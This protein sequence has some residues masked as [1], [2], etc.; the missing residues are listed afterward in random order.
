MSSLKLFIIYK[1]KGYAMIIKSNIKA[2]GIINHNEKLASDNKV[3]SFTVKTGIKAG[4]NFTKIEYNNHNE[5]LQSDIN[6]IE[7]KK[8]I[9]KKLRLSKETIRE[10]KDSDLKQIAG[11]Y[12]IRTHGCSVQSQCY[13]C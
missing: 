9:G 7:Q 12:I 2:G 3:K 10:L 11:G 1:E 4:F 13:S 8:T 5:K 6:T